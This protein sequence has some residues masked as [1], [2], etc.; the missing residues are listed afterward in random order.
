MPTVSLKTHTETKTFEVAE[1]EILFDAL[2]TQGE[3]LPHGCLSGSCGSCRII[4]TSGHENLTPPKAIE[5]DTI[6]HLKKEYQRKEELEKIS[7]GELRLSC[8]ARVQG[9]IS[10]APVEK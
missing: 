10:F 6:A 8:R 2:E 5:S 1:G 7:G 3:L 9:D 4:V